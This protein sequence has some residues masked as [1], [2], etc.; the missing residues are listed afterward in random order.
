MNHATLSP[1]TSYDDMAQK[2]TDKADD[3]IGTARQAA[4]GALDSLQEKATHL[5][6]VAPGTLSRV[7]AQ[8][9]DLTR[10]GM[11]R[12]KAATDTAK[13]QA[14]L[15]GDRTVSYIR[16][17]PVRAVLIAAAAGAAVATLIGLLSSN[18]RADR[19]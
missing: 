10:R 13:D 16:N 15:A 9:D 14:A 18:R 8:I 3:M 1:T 2:V 5:A 7:A 19:A 6:S 11:E 12:A 4:D 17:E